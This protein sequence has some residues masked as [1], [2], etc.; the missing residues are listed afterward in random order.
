MRDARLLVY[1]GG[2]EGAC[3]MV[4]PPLTIALEALRD[5]LDQLCRIIADT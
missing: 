3:V 2:R 4:L 5:G 1:G